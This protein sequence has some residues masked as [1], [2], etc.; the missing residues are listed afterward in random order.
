MGIELS[1]RQIAETV[2]SYFSHIESKIELPHQKIGQKIFIKNP[3]TF[4]GKNKLE[5]A[6]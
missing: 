5:N 1:E 2:F 6:V 3:K 4:W